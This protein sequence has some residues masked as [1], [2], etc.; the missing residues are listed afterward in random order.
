MWR[1]TEFRAPY[2]H[3]KCK[4]N[5]QFIYEEMYICLKC[6]QAKCRFCLEEEVEYFYCK[7][8]QDVLAPMEA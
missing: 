5:R 3:Y 8:C 4:C 2:V 6:G 7:F 1:L